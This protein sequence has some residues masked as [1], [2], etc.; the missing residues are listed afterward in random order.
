M[1]RVS[2]LHAI[3]YETLSSFIF[4]MTNFIF[5]SLFYSNLYSLTHEIVEDSYISCALRAMSCW[6][7]GEFS[8]QFERLGSINLISALTSTS[9]SAAYTIEGGYQHLRNILIDAVLSSGGVIITDTPMTQ[10]LF[11]KKNEVIGVSIKSEDG[12]NDIEIKSSKGVVS[13]IGAISTFV[14]LIPSSVSTPSIDKCCK[15]LKNLE[16]KRPKMYL[17]FNLK[18]TYES[19]GLSTSE[20][21]E[22]HNNNDDTLDNNNINNSADSSN[23]Q[24][25]NYLNRSFKIWSPSSRDKDWSQQ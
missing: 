24:N 15:K 3:F 12:K 19:L 5:S 2:F 18:G 23:N 22:L 21:L 11:N 8:A 7:S 9:K 20:Y 13:G 14:Q 6:I 1:F 4:E 25:N 10:L 17:L 16:V